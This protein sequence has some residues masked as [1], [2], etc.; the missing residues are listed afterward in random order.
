LTQFLFHIWEF[1]P[2][3]F[4]FIKGR[5]GRFKNRPT[6]Y[7]HLYL[8]RENCTSPGGRGNPQILFKMETV[9]NGKKEN[10]GEERWHIG[11]VRSL[12]AEASHRRGREFL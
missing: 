9:K 4:L 10:K 2:N 11:P 6:W 8:Q 3:S 12:A 7:P 5:L 1:E